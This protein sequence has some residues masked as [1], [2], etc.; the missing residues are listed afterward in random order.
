MLKAMRTVFFTGL[1][2]VNPVFAQPKPPVNAS[3]KGGDEPSAFKEFFKGLDWWIWVLLVLL[4]VLIGVFFWVRN[5]STE[6]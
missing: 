1:L 2:M 6:E 3:Y 5:R 4:F